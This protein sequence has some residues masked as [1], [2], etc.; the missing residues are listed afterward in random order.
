M[1]SAIFF[2]AAA[3]A[4]I[5]EDFVAFVKDH[6]KQYS[7]EEIASRFETFKVNK[8][9]IDAHNAMELGWTQAINEFTDLT[10][11][12]FSGL[13]KGYKARNTDFYRELNTATFPAGLTVD[14]DINWNT[15]GA[16]TPVKDQG[17]CGSCW[18]FSTT[19]GLEGATQI[20]TGKLLSMAE[21]QLVDCAGSAGNQGCN[22]GLM[23]DAFT[24]IKSNGGITDEASYPYTAKDGTCKTGM[25]SVA[26]LKSFT[27]VKKGSEDDLMAALQ[28]GPVSIA[29]DAQM[30][31]QTYSGG[32][33]SGFCGKSLDHGVLLVGSGTD[34]GQD[35]WL[36]KNSWG[37]SWGEKG[38]IRILRGSDKCGIADAA[39][40]PVV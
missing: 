18:S 5:Q 22:G 34:A 40:Q 32:V 25:T 24:W 23:D 39:S 36:V 30:G 31:W 16:V 10:P 14:A 15:K 7:Q 19:G 20:A 11:T 4:T 12:E 21:Q 33:L 9:A 28:T 17:Q 13:Y 38:Y 35:Y 2:A 27:D 29:V 3:S 26:T 37:A 6:K 1:K 8:Q